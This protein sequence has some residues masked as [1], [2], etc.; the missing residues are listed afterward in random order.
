MHSTAYNLISKQSQVS[1]KAAVS[2]TDDE[3]DTNS[4]RSLTVWPMAFFMVST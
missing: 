1:A 3:L 2:K 4:Y